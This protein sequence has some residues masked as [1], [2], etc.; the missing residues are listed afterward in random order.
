MPQHTYHNTENPTPT[1][2][3]QIFVNSKNTTLFQAKSVK[4][5]IYID[6]IRHEKGEKKKNEERHLVLLTHSVLLY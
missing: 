6:S 2:L 4:V 1:V 5:K 3:L